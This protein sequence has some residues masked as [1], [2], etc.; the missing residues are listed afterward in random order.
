MFRLT[1]INKLSLWF[2]NSIAYTCGEISRNFDKLIDPDKE[3]ELI[4][5]TKVGRIKKTK[6]KQ[7]LD[8]LTVIYKFL[9]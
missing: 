8:S 2:W 7:A 6:P 3:V 9:L 5:K 4:K 1:F